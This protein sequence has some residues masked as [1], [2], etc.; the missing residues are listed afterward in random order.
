MWS[1]SSPAASSMILG[2]I[3]QYVQPMY[4]GSKGS[5]LMYVSISWWPE[6]RIILG[7]TLDCCK[8]FGFVV[9]MLVEMCD[10]LYYV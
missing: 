3:R 4:A 5:S 10:R 9:Y 8:L 2:G 6:M 7:R 1:C